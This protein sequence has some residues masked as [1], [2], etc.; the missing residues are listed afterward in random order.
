MTRT[1]DAE[2]VRRVESFVSDW[3]VEASVPGAA[4][5]LVDRD[6]TLYADGFGARDLASNAPATPRTLFGIGS[7]T[8]SLTAYAVLALAD[9]G[10]LALPHPVAEYV[11]L[12]GADP[13]APVTIGDV[14]ADWDGQL[15]GASPDF[16]ADGV[17]RG[18]DADGDNAVGISDLG[19]LAGNYDQSGM[20]WE[21]GDF[22]GDGAIDVGDLGVL[23]GSY[24]W[25][26]AGGA[27]A[28]PVPEPAA[29]TVLLF[30]APLA[31]ARRRR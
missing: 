19:I 30:A 31:L 29:M 16:G 9:E 20:T 10:A 26:L 23:A 13:G 14:P 21:D 8:K 1:L 3:T 28:A 6:G 5:A 4:L 7:C 15:R 12:A 22:T 27:G 18:G 25:T 11:D 24:G 17:R 2:A